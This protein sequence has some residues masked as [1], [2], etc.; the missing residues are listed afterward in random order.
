MEFLSNHAEIMFHLVVLFLRFFSD[1]PDRRMVLF[2][3]GLLVEFLVQRKITWSFGVH[4]VLVCLRNLGRDRLRVVMILL[5]D[6]DSTGKIQLFPRLALARIEGLP[7]RIVG[8]L[9]CLGLSRSGILHII[10]GFKFSGSLNA[11]V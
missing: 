10:I 8:F 4:A 5:D 7:L 11:V 1:V 9:E 3:G 6:F 2:A